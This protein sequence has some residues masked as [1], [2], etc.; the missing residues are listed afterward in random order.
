MIG[1]M[2]LKLRISRRL[3][4]ADVDGG[5][6]GEPARG[7]R[8]GEQHSVIAVGGRQNLVDDG[9]YFTTQNPTPGTALAAPVAASFSDTSAAFLVYNTADPNEPF[10]KHIYLDH[11]KLCFTV[12]P[13]SATG[14][15]LL[16]RLDNA[17]RT[18]TAGSAVL[19]GAGGS[20]GAVAP[21]SAVAQSIA[22]IWSFTGAAMMTLPA[23]TTLGKVAA[24][25]GIDGIPVVGGER[26]FAFGPWDV[27]SSGQCARCN[28]I[29]VPPG[30]SCAFHLWWPG[31][32]ATG[33][34]VEPEL[35]WW[36]R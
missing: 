10:A 2:L 7:N 19:V 1:E 28:P 34:S 22:R 15:R 20:P 17:V 32:A 21:G 3:P 35:S 27:P 13:A 5:R 30:W 9:T 31:N 16:A 8:Y 12:A 23:V 4:Q 6:D 25:A 18:P 26:V 33:A 29:D 14:T 11:L 36:E 24:L